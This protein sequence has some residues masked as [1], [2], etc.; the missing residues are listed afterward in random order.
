MKLFILNIVLIQDWYFQLISFP[1]SFSDNEKK[2]RKLAYICSILLHITDSTVRV[3]ITIVY[4]N[5][6]E[7][8]SLNFTR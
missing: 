5:F 2:F 6:I 4:M 1:P 3:C 8:S 7:T